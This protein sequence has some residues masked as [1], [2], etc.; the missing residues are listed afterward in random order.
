M[1]SDPIGQAVQRS[2]LAALPPDT[3]EA[4]LADAIRLDVPAG[5]VMYRQGDP[6]RCGLLV[7]GL[8][9]IFLAAP[10]GRQVT[11]RYMPPGSLSGSAL[12]VRGPSVARMQAVSD[13][14]ALVLNAGSLRVLA[15]GGSPHP[16]R[17]AR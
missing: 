3:L 17:R 13:I 4:L 11:I 6:P 1:W 12:V 10:D 15:R 14:S 8:A 7:S 9:R 2:V 16:A 5:S